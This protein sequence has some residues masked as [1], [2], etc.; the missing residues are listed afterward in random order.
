MRIHHRG[1]DDSSSLRSEPFWMGFPLHAAHIP[2]AQTGIHLLQQ[3]FNRITE[4]F[5]RRD[6]DEGIQLK[7]F[8]QRQVTALLQNYN[9]L[10]QNLEGMIHLL[11][12]DDE[13][14]NQLEWLTEAIVVHRARAQ[15]LSQQQ[16]VSEEDIVCCFENLRVVAKEVTEF[17]EE[18]ATTTHTIT[19]NYVRSRLAE[20]N[21]ALE[22]LSQDPVVGTAKNN[23]M[24][25]ALLQ[26][27]LQSEIKFSM[28]LIAGPVMTNTTCIQ[29][30]NE[31]S[32]MHIK[33]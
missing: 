10:S 16:F 33:A 11:K 19:V 9:L 20:V 21:Q 31:F 7:E 27:P 5:Q 26:E 8:P 1:L 6:C 17:V 18:I 24:L 2:L 29:V 32:S 3:G 30:L 15:M 22:N 12:S 23:D 28:N 25:G 14:G 4:W 13:A